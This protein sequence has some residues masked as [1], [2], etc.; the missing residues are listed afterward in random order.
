MLPPEQRAQ[1][2]TR[3]RPR[4][5]D[6]A[7]APAGAV[8]GPLPILPPD[9]WATPVEVGEGFVL[10]PASPAQEQMWTLNQLLPDSTGY[11]VAIAFRLAGPLD[12]GALQQAWGDL[13]GRHDAL[14]T[15]LR[16]ERGRLWQV[17]WDSPGPAVPPMS[18]AGPVPEEPGD[19]ARWLGHSAW[20][21]F[22]MDGQPL[23]RWMGVAT[24]SGDHL[25]LI[26]FHHAI[27][28]GTSRAVLLRELGL[29][30]EARRAGR[31]PSFAPLRF[32]ESR[33]AAW[34][35]E[36]F[37]PER[38]RGRREAWVNRLQGRP[39]EVLV[40]ADHRSPARPSGQGGVATRTLDPELSAG[41]SRLARGW[42]T[43]VF[44][45]LEAS[46]AVLLQQHGAGDDLVL[47]TASANRP[48]VELES[49][50]GCQVNV[51]P[52]RFD[53]SGNPTFAELVGRVHRVL[54]EGLAESEFPFLRVAE[55][56]GELE[57][58]RS[59][60]LLEVTFQFRNHP[61]AHLAL[62]GLTVTPLALD[63]TG[64]TLDLAVSAEPWGEGL[65]LTAEY[66][67]DRFADATVVAWLARWEHLLRG[68][69][70]RPEA[71]LAE[72]SCLPEA[73][74]HHWVE[75]AG[76]GPGLP[77]S[78]P[79][80]V[81]L[82]A[83]AV[84]RFPEAV[85]VEDGWRSL[86]FGDLDRWSDRIAARLGEEGVGAGTPVGMDASRSAEAVACLLGIAKAGGAFVPLDPNQPPARLAAMIEDAGMPVILC[87]VADRFA[88]FAGPGRR[89]LDPGTGPGDGVGAQAGS[90]PVP[91]ASSLAYLLYTSGSTG[92]PKAV[93][94]EHGQLAA[95]LA[96][97][98]ERYPV[99]AGTGAPVHSPLTFDL[100][101]TSLLLP[102][103][104]GRRVWMLP[105]SGALEALAGLMREN[106]DFSLIKL[107]PSH[108]VALDLLL[109]EADVR[110]SARSLVVGGEVL[111]PGVAAAWLRRLPEAKLFNEYGPTEATVGCCVHEVQPAD[112]AR[113]SIPIGRPVPG[114]RVR[115]LDA[116][117][118][119]VP[120]GTPGELVLGGRQVAR[121][122][123]RASG[124]TAERFHE[125]KD[126]AGPITRWYRTGDRC[127]WL[128]NGTLEYLGREDEQVKIRGF[129]IELGEIEDALTAIPRIRQ[130]AVVCQAGSGSAGV[131]AAYLVPEGSGGPSVPE[132]RE[133]L[134]HRLPEVMIPVVFRMVES[135]PVNGQGKL[136]RVALARLGSSGGTP[137][138]RGPARL[139]TP[140][141]E[142][143][144]RIWSEIL[145]VSA[146]GPE[147]EFLALGGHSLRAVQLLVRLRRELGVDLSLVRVLE[148]P[149]LA[150]LA[151]E[152]DRVRQRGP[153]MPPLRALRRTHGGSNA[154]PASR[155]G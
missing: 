101:L 88:P 48:R 137:L 47:G 61:P 143:L 45:V 40:G 54:T 111:L 151:A 68:V 120:P 6:G 132:L 63:R 16:F 139:L 117:G 154:T 71:R 41:L 114:T 125:G 28:D 19:L 80:L 39:A 102:L 130:A 116:Q 128:A 95:Y 62:E 50:L 140:T 33:F 115:V 108:L 144:S 122:Y 21:T 113:G 53:L 12:S 121:G 3:L 99:E 20:Q 89:L 106:R 14:R 105:E 135:L 149:R 110:R 30:Y 86:T 72:V 107:T 44:A 138:A 74:R 42:G 124:P 10:V 84:A 11:H 90:R 127:R 26:V 66:A 123:W 98:R 145:G 126:A 104:C 147:D 7:I 22:L 103:I 94:V 56:L 31:S 81:Q 77:E 70:A 142:A 60:P 35:A 1:L 112:V 25:L 36:R 119:V 13:A 65:L 76:A 52:L 5:G 155:A 43:T 29:A 59:G 67:F 75:V 32:G 18:P 91:E 79:G 131:L 133:H 92:R 78:L 109:G 148:R 152:V 136:D 38:C 49:L 58:G 57:P 150:D 46:L 9:H 87:P 153:A 15:G 69:V 82:W 85:A 93:A 4:A 64:V 27:S 118:R 146:P 141:E 134:R 34:Q 96:W 23:W 97:A 83:T 51:L 2:L 100:T 17:V 24:P 55:F 73:E 37:S 129:R 8:A